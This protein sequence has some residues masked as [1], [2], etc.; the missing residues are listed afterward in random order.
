MD[1]PST[2]SRHIKA[3]N[4]IW[5]DRYAHR[6]DSRRGKGGEKEVGGANANARVAKMEKESLVSCLLID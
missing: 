3:C 1:T 5:I 4:Y 2:A 6:V